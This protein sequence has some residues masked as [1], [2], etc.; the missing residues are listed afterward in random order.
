MMLF[1][2][3][4]DHHHNCLQDVGQSSRR[5]DNEFLAT[6]ARIRTGDEHVLKNDHH[7]LSSSEEELEEPSEEDDNK[8]GSPQFLRDV[9]AARVS[10]C[11]GVYLT[12]F[13]EPMGT[14][15]SKSPMC[16]CGS[17]PQ[18]VCEDKC[19]G[20]SSLMMERLHSQPLKRKKMILRMIYII[21]SECGYCTITKSNK[22]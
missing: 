13:Y 21:Q 19:Y 18:R 6:L 1:G 12:E 3:G 20:C 14:D 17:V 4:A 7:T 8:D 11:G 15:L 2:F 5:K 22:I 9:Q 10:D 16:G